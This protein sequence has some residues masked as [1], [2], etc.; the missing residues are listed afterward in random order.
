MVRKATGEDEKVNK[1]IHPVCGNLKQ[2]T[3]DVP[4]LQ[5]RGY[6]CRPPKS[7]DCGMVGRDEPAL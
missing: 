5:K 3:V 6:C 1:F 7:V 2:M 4:V